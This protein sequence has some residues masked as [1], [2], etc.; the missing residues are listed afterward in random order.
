LKPRHTRQP[1]NRAKKI[2]EQTAIHSGIKL[3]EIVSIVNFVNRFGF[4]GGASLNTE[5]AVM[6]S[7][8]PIAT[9]PLTLYPPKIER[10]ASVTVTY[11]IAP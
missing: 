1:S 2:A 11:T 6:A 5:S 8:R 10:E 7:S 9:V 4:G 3:G